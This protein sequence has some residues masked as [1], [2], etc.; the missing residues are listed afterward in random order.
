MDEVSLLIDLVSSKWSS[1]VTTLVNAG[2]IS[3]DHAGTPNFVDVRTLQKNKGVRYDLT[4]KDVIVFFEDSQNI[5]YPTINF[6]VRNE[7]YSFTM[8]M[9]TIHDERAGTDADF[10]RD[11]LRAIYLIARHTLERGRTGYTASDGS[12]FNQVFVGSRSESNDRSKRLFGY[13]L[14]VETKRFALTLP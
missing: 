1:S 7:T 6:D 10:G 9:R 2:T 4:A 5:E 14:S 8:H 11:R 3:A 12:K 13:K